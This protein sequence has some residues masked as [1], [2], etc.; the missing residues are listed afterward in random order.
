[1]VPLSP[2][3]PKKK[4]RV[5]HDVLLSASHNTQRPEG[6][7]KR[8][9]SNESPTFLNSTFEITQIGPQIHLGLFYQVPLN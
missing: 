4:S 8:K 9:L 3:F 1:M 6:K 2:Q 7:N 5:I